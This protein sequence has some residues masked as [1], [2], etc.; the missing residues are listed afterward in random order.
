MDLRK[1][2]PVTTIKNKD[3]RKSDN[4]EKQHP[5]LESFVSQT[6]TETNNTTVFP[7]TQVNKIPVMFTDGASRGNPG[8]ASL[9]VAFFSDPNYVDA[10]T[11]PDW[12]LSKYLGNRT[13]NFAEYAAII[14]GLR[15][16]HNRGIK[17]IEIR[18]DSQLLLR[19]LLGQY[20][21][22]SPQMIPLYN[23]SIELL[24][25]MDEFKLTHV[26]GHQGIYGNELADKL[27]NQALDNI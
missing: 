12:T 15:E 10:P 7:L 2:F 9:G 20:K 27:A 24:G 3:E 22:K 8:K 16:C 6:Q 23:R 4:T 13:N 21:V 18:T 5:T 17:K 25:Q 11:L 1:F 26:R 19:Q 14:E